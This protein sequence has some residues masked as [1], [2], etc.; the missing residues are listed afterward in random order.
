MYIASEVQATPRGEV[1]LDNPGISASAG[2]RREI[3]V[4]AYIQSLRKT[5]KNSYH[6]VFVY[7]EDF[8]NTSALFSQLELQILLGKQIVELLSDSD[9]RRFGTLKG[10]RLSLLGSSRDETHYVRGR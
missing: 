6:I 5:N 9:C 7:G 1:N 10:F 4:C 8:S 3:R 2:N